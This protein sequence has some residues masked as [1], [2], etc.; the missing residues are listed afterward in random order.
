MDEKHHKKPPKTFKVNPVKSVRRAKTA[1]TGRR[2]LHDLDEYFRGLSGFGMGAI[3]LTDHVTTYG[4]VTNQGLQIL[5]EVFKRHAPLSG[6]TTPN[7]NFFDLGCGIGKAVVG[8]A[9]LVPEIHS[10]GIE[11]VPDRIRIAQTAL[12]ALSRIHTRNLSSRIQI[13]QGNF[14][15]PGIS[16]GSSCWIFIS[17]LGF[18]AETQRA[19]AERLEN[20]CLSGSVVICIREL[21][22]STDSV[23]FE[24]VGSNITIPMTW[25]ATSTC[26]V[27]K[28]R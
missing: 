1:R 4:E 27:Y 7:R 21:P 14:L 11:I 10:N 9:L 19:L 15:E 17:N 23:R 22:F 2:G 13:R 16:Y 28:R 26:Q 25:S 8:L 5:T 20:E 3:G 12:S 24:R 18:T 6:F